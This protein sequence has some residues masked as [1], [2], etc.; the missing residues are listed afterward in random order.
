MSKILKQARLDSELVEEI[1]KVADS[2]HSGNFTAAL[3]S[4]VKQSV[5]IRSI[6]EQKRWM[7]YSGAK[8][9]GAFR[10]CEERD[11]ITLTNKMTDGLLI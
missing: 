10:N 6:D 11:Y 3:E 8:R 7:M 2:E 4:M 9:L 1:Q 5:A